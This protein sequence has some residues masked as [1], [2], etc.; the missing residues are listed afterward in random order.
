LPRR[1]CVCGIRST[2]SR[3]PCHVGVWRG[4]FQCAPWRLGNPSSMVGR[5]PNRDDRR[6]RARR[7]RCGSGGVKGV[8]ELIQW[9]NSALNGRSPGSS[10]S[11][12]VIV[13]MSSPWG[14]RSSRSVRTG[15]SPSR[16]GVNLKARLS[17]V[18]LGTPTPRAP[19]DQGPLNTAYAATI[20]NGLPKD[21]PDEIIAFFDDD[22]AA[23]VLAHER[24]LAAGRA[25]ALSSPALLIENTPP[26]SQVIAF[27]AYLRSASIAADARCVTLGGPMAFGEARKSAS[28][29]HSQGRAE[30]H[31]AH[32]AF[33]RLGGK[34]TVRLQHRTLS[35][36]PKPPVATPTAT[37]CSAQL[38]PGNPGVKKSGAVTSIA[39]LS[40]YGPQQSG[41]P[42]HEAGEA[43]SRNDA[44]LKDG[45]WRYGSGSP[46][47]ASRRLTSDDRLAFDGRSPKAVAETVLDHLIEALAG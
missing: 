8:P 45:P 9:I 21:A 42:H 13:P 14:I 20:D 6:R 47:M 41:L 37:I 39:T 15:L 25:I 1:G 32:A 12:V 22:C 29:A 43:E 11:S 46:C 28:S 31:L 24:S 16:L 30:P 38:P 3:M 40:E 5:F 23:A 17:E 26:P 19:F 34:P 2:A 36:W 7:W 18:Q 4:G 33:G 27:P 35:M 44:K 10:A